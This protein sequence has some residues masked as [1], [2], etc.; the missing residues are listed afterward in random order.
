MTEHDD[1]LTPAERFFQAENIKYFKSF[2]DL[3]DGEWA[4]ID[5]MLSLQDFTQPG[6]EGTSTPLDFYRT[7]FGTFF[8]VVPTNKPVHPEITTPLYDVYIDEKQLFPETV[9]DDPNVVDI[10]PYVNRAHNEKIMEWLQKIFGGFE[11]GMAMEDA[12]DIPANWEVLRER[13][14][15]SVA[16]AEIAMISTD[17]QW[18][19]VPLREPDSYKM[20]HGQV[21][22]LVGP[23]A[24]NPEEVPITDEPIYP[25]F[26]RDLRLI[27]G[28][29]NNDQDID[30]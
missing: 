3:P 28:E 20:L 27:Q 23:P 15:T 5:D 7:E 14:N 4:R 30:K 26:S 13:I 21:K 16:L 17:R 8:V 1:H 6:E 19:V 22:L 10:G 2:E 18:R 9:E 11:N 25:L 24:L 29:G 12:F